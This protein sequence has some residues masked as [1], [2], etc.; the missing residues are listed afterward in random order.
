[1]SKDQ[2]GNGVNGEKLSVEMDK[3]IE[4]GVS[5]EL[6]LDENDREVVVTEI[7]GKNDGKGIENI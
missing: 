6:T 5:F 2:K 1:M 3:T 7:D 4:N